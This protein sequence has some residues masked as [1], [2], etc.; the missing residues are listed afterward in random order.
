MINLRPYNI[1]EWKIRE[2]KIEFLSVYLFNCL[3]EGEVWKAYYS[4]NQ[5]SYY[6]CIESKCHARLK[7]T[8]KQLNH[9]EDEGDQYQDGIMSSSCLKK[10]FDLIIPELEISE[11]GKHENHASNFDKL[12]DKRKKGKF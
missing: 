8:E 10:E 1:Q 9:E 12:V 11:S 6:K 7:I 4:S 2:T 5:T 3:Q